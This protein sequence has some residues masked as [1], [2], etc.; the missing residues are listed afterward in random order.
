MLL[1]IIRDEHTWLRAAAISVLGLTREPRHAPLYISHLRDRSDRVINA[2]A[3]ALGR[4]RSPAALDALAALPPHP[5][6]KN[7]S[8]ISALAGLR[9]LADPRGAHIA[10]RALADRRSPRWTLTTPVWD[11]RIAAADTLATL[12]QTDASTTLVLQ[13]F[14]SALADGD[15]NDI[16]SN[17]HLL[18]ALGHPRARTIFAPLKQ[19]F[20]ADANAMQAVQN[21]ETQLEAKLRP[22]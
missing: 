20:A 19:R 6:W 8:L 1:A 3:I 15:V 4:S 22:P 14:D 9:E 18:V 2:A 21:Y 7:Q 16:F 5:S 17:V 10:S 13:D 12:K 11:Y